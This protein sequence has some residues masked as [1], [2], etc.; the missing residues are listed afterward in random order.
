MRSSDVEPALNQEILKVSGSSSPRYALKIDDE[1]VADLTKDQLASGVNLAELNTPMLRQAR[2]V[3]ELTLR[4]NNLHFRAWRNVQ[5]P[6]EGREYP[7]MA[8]A[9]EGLDA[10]EADM[11]AEQRQKA[12]PVPHRFELLPQP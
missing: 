6:N 7:R 2:A 1:K 5:V 4:H 8:K 11:V 10:L 9:I 12:K 3:H